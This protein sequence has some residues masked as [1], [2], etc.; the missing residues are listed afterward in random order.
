MT[1]K[2]NSCNCSDCSQQSGQDYGLTSVRFVGIEFDPKKINSQQN[3]LNGAL[4]QNWQ[5]IKDIQTET[6]LVFILGKFG[7]LNSD[8]QDEQD[9]LPL[10]SDLRDRQSVFDERTSRISPEEEEALRNTFDANRRFN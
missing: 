10:C 1:N 5:L 8:E 7:R 2:R 6:G 4:K 9:E 3:E